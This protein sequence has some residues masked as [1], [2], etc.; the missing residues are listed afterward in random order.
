MFAST[1]DIFFSVYARPWKAKD[2][3]SRH[4]V[5][6]GAF[7][8]VRAKVYRQ[9]GTHKAIAMRP[10]DDI[11]LGKLLKRQGYRQE[12]AFGPGMIRVEWY[13]S[14]R[15]VIDGLMKNCFAG[16]EYSIPGA[17]AGGVALLLFNFWPVPGLFLTHGLT[18]VLNGLIVLAMVFIAGVNNRYFGLP[19]KYAVGQPFCSLLFTYIIW[20]SM[21]TALWHDGIEWRGT[22]YPL[23]VLKANRI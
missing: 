3:E 22:R 15:E 7:N 19:R 23:S 6:I 8:L 20:R 12:M 10:D 16:V 9:A 21:L 18:R 11:K 5:G 17:I 1:F 13:A 14:L 4:S 2:P